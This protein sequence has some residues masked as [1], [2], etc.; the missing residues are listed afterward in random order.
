[1]HPRVKQLSLLLACAPGL[2]AVSGCRDFLPRTHTTSSSPDGRHTA[3]VRQGFNID[4]PDDHLYLATAGQA[5]RRL[6]DLTGDVL[7]FDS[8]NEPAA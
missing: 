8:R 7:A 4:P 1:M 6:L 2:V 5:P 3:Y